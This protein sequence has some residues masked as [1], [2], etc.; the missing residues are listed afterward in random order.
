M[1][2]QLN[3]PPQQAKTDWRWVF[4]FTIFQRH[5]IFATVPASLFIGWAISAVS[6]KRAAVLLEQF[7]LVDAAGKL[8][9]EYS[10][11][12]RRR[13]DLAGAHGQER[14]AGEP[15]GGE[16]APQRARAAGGR[17]RGGQ[18]EGRPHQQE[19]DADP[20]DVFPAIDELR[21]P[22]A[23][24]ANMLTAGDEEPVRLALEEIGA[25]APMVKLLV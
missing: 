21:I 12:M 15:G 19:T 17:D 18:H 6:T 13:L 7:S 25:I 5:I 1:A 11:G 4:E 14:E 22:I 9:K 16:G 23:Y 8:A 2:H 3:G 10:G 24:L 20:D